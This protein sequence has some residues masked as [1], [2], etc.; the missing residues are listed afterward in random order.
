MD[1]IFFSVLPWD[2]I[3]HSTQRSAGDRSSAPLK[4]LPT[5]K[6]KA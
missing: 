6:G 2:W 4:R 5:L 1:A 3:W